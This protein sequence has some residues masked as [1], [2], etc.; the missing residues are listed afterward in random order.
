MLMQPKPDKTSRT[1]RDYDSIDK[2]IDGEAHDW[3]ILTGTAP[4]RRRW[5]LGA[6]QP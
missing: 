5:R 4:L 2:A 3:S 1:F 6:V